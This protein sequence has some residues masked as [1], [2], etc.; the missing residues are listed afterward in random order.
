M[1]F[2]E[3]AVIITVTIATIFSIRTFIKQFSSKKPSCT[4]CSCESSAKKSFQRS[5]NALRYKKI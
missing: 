1:G 4:S 2:Q 5:R 3:I